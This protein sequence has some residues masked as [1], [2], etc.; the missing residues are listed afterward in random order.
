M[1]CWDILKAQPLRF[2]SIDSG[3]NASTLM[4]KVN[5]ALIGRVNIFIFSY[6]ASKNL[7]VMYKQIYALNHLYAYF[8]CVKG[9]PDLDNER[10]VQELLYVLEHSLNNATD[11]ILSEEE[12]QRITPELEIMARLKST[13]L[14]NPLAVLGNIIG[15]IDADEFMQMQPMIL[16]EHVK[17]PDNGVFSTFKQGIHTYFKLWGFDDTDKF[18]PFINRAE[19]VDEALMIYQPEQRDWFYSALL[20]TFHNLLLKCNEVKSV[21]NVGTISHYINALSEQ[22]KI[23]IKQTFDQDFNNLSTDF[24]NYLQNSIIRNPLSLTPE[25]IENYT[26]ILLG[27]NHQ[28]FWEIYEREFYYTPDQLNDGLNRITDIPFLQGACF[29]Y[30]WL[31]AVSQY[32]NDQVPHE[33]P[34]SI[35]RTFDIH[36]AILNRPLNRY[37]IETIYFCA[38]NQREAGQMIESC[39]P[40]Y[41]LEFKHIF[42]SLV[43]GDVI[44]TFQNSYGTLQT[45]SPRFILSEEMMNDP[46][47]LRYLLRRNPLYLDIIRPEVLQNF[48]TLRLEALRSYLNFLIMNLDKDMINDYRDIHPHIEHFWPNLE[49]KNKPENDDLPFE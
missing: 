10:E 20:Y 7:K 34:F 9:N 12:A 17:A 16:R 15:G 31:V 11:F 48:Q 29:D 24:S 43:M 3:G 1:E 38:P 33:G 22:E 2:G 5:P 26:Q 42:S 44:A 4:V 13:L 23:M 45:R 37:K 40:L 47:F 28:D 19:A 8:H 6:F 36:A 46:K 27:I 32:L 39:F 14:H 25:Q 49:G 41:A 35:A 21:P 18:F 30:D